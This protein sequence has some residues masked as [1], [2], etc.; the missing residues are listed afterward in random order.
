MDMP[1]QGQDSRSWG[2]L[3][4]GQWLGAR[5]DNKWYQWPPQLSCQYFT[6][7]L[8]YDVNVVSVKVALFRDNQFYIVKTVQALSITLFSSSFWIDTYQTEGMWVLCK[9][10]FT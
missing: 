3:V 1:R 5:T 2:R 9:D 4:P 8:S 7:L 6:N 10:N